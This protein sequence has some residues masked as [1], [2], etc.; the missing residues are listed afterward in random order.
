MRE[1]Y[2]SQ[3]VLL[4]VLKVLKVTWKLGGLLTINER[5]VFWFVSDVQ[6]T[7][8]KA[9]TEE[10]NKKRI[11]LGGRRWGLRAK[12]TFTFCIFLERILGSQDM[13]GLTVGESDT[14]VCHWHWWYPALYPQCLA[15]W[16]AGRGRGWMMVDMIFLGAMR[17]RTPGRTG[18][19]AQDWLLRVWFTLQ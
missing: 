16:Q 17:P 7:Y 19:S 15:G 10:K 13:I 18:L 5:G 12:L 9:G 3:S 1:K 2:V 11:Q 6:L 4:C 8:F 14:L